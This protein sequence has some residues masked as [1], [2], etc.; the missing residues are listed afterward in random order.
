MVLEGLEYEDIE[1]DTLESELAPPDG[2]EDREYDAFYVDS[3]L[4]VLD[5]RDRQILID[6]Y[7]N[8]DNSVEDDNTVKAKCDAIGQRYGLT[9]G[10]IWQIVHDKAPEKILDYLD[11]R[12]RTKERELRYEK[13]HQDEDKKQYISIKD[14]LQVDM[15][16]LRQM[17]GPYFVED[18][19]AEAEA[20]TEEVAEVAEAVAVVEKPAEVTEEPR[21][22]MPQRRKV[23][24]EGLAIG[25]RI[26]YK[27]LLFT[28][29][30]IVVDIDPRKEVMRVVYKNG[31]K[32]RL[33]I[34]A[35]RIRNLTAEKIAE[36]QQKRLEER[37][38]AMKIKAWENYSKSRKWY[39]ESIG[40]KWIKVQMAAD[41]S[42]KLIIERFNRYHRIGYREFG[43]R[44][45]KL[46]DSG[47]LSKWIKDL[48]DFEPSYCW[49]KD[50]RGHYTYCGDDVEELQ[51]E[52]DEYF[53]SYEA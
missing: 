51:A 49:A 9:G 4:K 16:K 2:F 41:L 25:D 10:R 53:D 43:T 13:V 29:K 35:K 1:L 28:L 46:L 31:M 3:L 20:A 34:S 26:E 19:A 36:Q 39:A 17:M 8:Y 27:S 33:R 12:A 50:G 11:W 42:R 21:K 7:Y 44:L 32:D 6:Y 37:K 18:N 24:Y 15:H 47:T 48:M 52:L 30:C 5:E 14:S 38:A 22:R 45:G 40:I 23:V